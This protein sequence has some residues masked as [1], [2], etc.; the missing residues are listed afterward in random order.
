MNLTFF[1]SEI[2]EVVRDAAFSV[3]GLQPNPCP[4]SAFS[5]VFTKLCAAEEAEVCPESFLF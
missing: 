5:T 2:E 3:S 4:Y 1:F